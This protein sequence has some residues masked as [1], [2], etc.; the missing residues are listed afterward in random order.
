[1]EILTTHRAV[2]DELGG[3]EAVIKLTGVKS[4]T[5][6]Y[7]WMARQKFPPELYVLMS[8]ALVG[9]GKTAPPSLWGQS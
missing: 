7:N 3:V 9:V 8:R 5:V 2:V 6:V 4:D 1:M